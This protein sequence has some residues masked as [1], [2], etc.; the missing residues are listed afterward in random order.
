MDLLS[1]LVSQSSSVAFFSIVEKEKLISLEQHAKNR[2]G[3]D[4]ERNL[5]KRGSCFSKEDEW[6]CSSDTPPVSE[7]VSRI[8]SWGNVG[9]RTSV[10]Y[11]GLGGAQGLTQCKQY[12]AC[13]PQIGPTVLWDDIV[14]PDWMV[15]QA[16]AIVKANPGSNPNSITD[17]FQK[18][19]SQAF[20]EASSGDAYVCTPES[21]APQNDF[22]Q[23][24]AWGG[25]EYP[26]LTRNSRVTRVFRV[27]PNTNVLALIWTQGDPPTPNAPRG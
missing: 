11:T 6:S 25:W 1:T 2:I 16:Q 19:M 17:P 9:S 15:A 22:D 20:G 26:A 21:N 14:D 8:Q 12:F 4:H 18:R 23:N 3:N 10:F 13:N 24:L 5:F 7:C 27:D